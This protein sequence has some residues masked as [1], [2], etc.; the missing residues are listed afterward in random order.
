[1]PRWLPKVLSRVRR[2]AVER[3][4]RFTLK[5][6]RELATLGLDVLDGCEALAGLTSG[7]AVGR[8]R[9]GRTGEWMYVVKPLVAGDVIYV[10]LILRNDCIVV[11]FHED[12]GD[13]DEEQEP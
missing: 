6:Q 7:D 10:K 1:M 4:V 12:E 2:L 11:S 13:R 8:L 5:A 9:S 3:R